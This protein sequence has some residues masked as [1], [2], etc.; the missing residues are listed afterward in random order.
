MKKPFMSGAVFSDSTSQSKKKTPS[1]IIARRAG[2]FLF[3]PDIP[4]IRDIYRRSQKSKDFFGSPQHNAAH[5][6]H[7]CRG[8]QVC[9]F[10]SEKK[11]DPKF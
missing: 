11:F 1:L 5:I 2:G 8:G 6:A 4:D 3:T 9:K 7:S 10:I